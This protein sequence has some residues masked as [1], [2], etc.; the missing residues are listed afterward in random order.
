M[1]GLI[2]CNNFYASCERVF[3]PSLIGKPVVVLSNNDGCIIARSNEA[4]ALGIKMGEPAFKIKELLE[5]HKVAVYSSNYTLY[6]DMSHRVM[7]IVSAHIPDMEIY[8]IDEAFLHFSDFSSPH[9]REVGLKIVRTVVRSTGIPV[10]LGIAPTKTLAK[11]ANRFAK[12]HAGYRDVCVIDTDEKRLKA[13]SLTHIGDIWGVGPRYNEKLK[14][15]GVHTALDFTSKSRLWVRKLM[16]VVGERTWLELNGIPSLKMEVPS[17]KKTICT[18]RSFGVTLTQF[19]AVAE[20][21]AHFAASGA[22]KLRQ[23]NSVAG[24]LL[25]FL[26]TNPFAK[27]KPQYYNQ[28]YVPLSVPTNDTTELVHFAVQGL[29]GIFKEGF[30]YKKAGVILSDISDEFPKQTDLFDT[31]ARARF[32]SVMKVM[33]SLNNRYGRMKVRVATQGFGRQWKM[34]NEQLSPCYTTNLDEIVIVNAKE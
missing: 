10:S 9:L 28:L 14:Y 32:S 31:R 3:N 17:G 6:G 8:S 34:K 29:S 12:K 24:G 23:Q 30:S 5:R 22:L 20:S 18:S 2:D 1:F 16:G 13:L 33:D 26:H 25:V 15:Y 19:H 11:L 7:S 4:K 27:E 21:V